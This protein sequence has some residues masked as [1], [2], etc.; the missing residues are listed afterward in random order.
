L[1]KL[2]E[3][4]SGPEDNGVFPW[5]AELTD[6]D[7]RA[8]CQTNGAV[9]LRLDAKGIRKKEEF[10]SV[11]A[12]AFHFPDYFGGNWDSFEEIV[13]DPDW[14]APEGFLILLSDA[15]DFA[16]GRREDFDTFLEIMRD[17]ADYWRELGK[18]FFC[19]VDEL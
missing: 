11:A 5:R 12:A 4:I 9:C 1:N 15:G 16:Q 14:M 2:E 17:A 19:F 7:F 6:D 3:F 18:R 10:L 8:F 13:T